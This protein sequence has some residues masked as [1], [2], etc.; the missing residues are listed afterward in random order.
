MYVVYRVQIVITEYKQN[1]SFREVPSR[2]RAAHRLTPD[3][4]PRTLRVLVPE[5]DD[6]RQSVDSHVTD[7][8]QSTEAIA[9]GV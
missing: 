5:P 3:A 9:D 6:R 2:Q 7:R 4:D 8:A 1:K